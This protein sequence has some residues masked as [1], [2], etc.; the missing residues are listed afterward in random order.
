MTLDTIRDRLRVVLPDYM[1]PRAMYRVDVLPLT[2][3]GKVNKRDLAQRAAR[4]GQRLGSLP[5]HTDGE[6]RLA[7]AWAEV[8]EVP[9]EDIG[10]D[11]NF[12]D[13]GGTSLSAIRLA[14]KLG[15][16]LSLRDIV[17]FP[18][19]GD[20]ARLLEQA[21]GFVQYDGAHAGDLAGTTG[22]NSGGI[23]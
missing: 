12:F 14:I 20:L 16:R 11:E 15:R 23:Q 1:I 21:A 13:I 8:L 2:A 4:T 5:V 19:L 22:E 6:R 10:R 7:A 17:S 18:V 3:N 9:A